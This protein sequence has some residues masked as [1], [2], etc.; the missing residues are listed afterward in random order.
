MELAMTL[1]QQRLR[2]RLFV[3]AGT[4][5]KSRMPIH[6]FDRD[7]AAL[8]V[9]RDFIRHVSVRTTSVNDVW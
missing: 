2:V 4:K 7:S 6:S 9:A 1:Q 3:L 8:E 5:V